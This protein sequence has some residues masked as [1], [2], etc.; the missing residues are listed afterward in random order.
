MYLDILELVQCWQDSKLAFHSEVR[1]P[2]LP[3]PTST[4]VSCMLFPT[5]VSVSMVSA[6][7]QYELARM[8][9]VAASMLSHVGGAALSLSTCT[10]ASGL[11]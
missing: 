4:T 6:R 11:V 8:H 9:R 10:P 2:L 7:L 3:L 5:T 1:T